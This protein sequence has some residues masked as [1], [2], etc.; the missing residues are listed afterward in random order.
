[1][2]FLIRLLCREAE[3]P[4]LWRRGLAWGRRNKVSIKALG[5]N[6]AR[7]AKH[8]KVLLP[9]PITLASGSRDTF[10]LGI[11][12]ASTNPANLVRPEV[13]LKACRHA[14]WS[15]RTAAASSGWR[16]KHPAQNKDSKNADAE[17]ERPEGRG[18]RPGWGRRERAATSTRQQQTNTQADSKRVE[19]DS[20]YRQL[21]VIL[22]NG[23]D[24]LIVQQREGE[25]ERGERE[26]EREEDTHV[27]HAVHD[28]VDGTSTD[29]QT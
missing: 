4:P 16:W 8:A 2:L 15:W 12:L 18:E 1:M 26:R 14:V 24:R 19:Q 21:S 7:L 9:R 22:R 25:E 28:H 3:L 17:R 27:K 23:R 6:V 29:T 5:P 10:L 13:R 11:L 20:T